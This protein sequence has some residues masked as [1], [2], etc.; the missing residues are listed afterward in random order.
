MNR[1]HYITL[2]YKE[3]TSELS[4]LEVQ[5]LEDFLQE[6]SAN[7]DLRDEIQLSWMLSQQVEK[8]SELDIDVEADLK[9]V[10]T[11][12]GK[13]PPSQQ[14]NTRRVVPLWRR[15]ATV[16]AIL[17]PLIIAGAYFF[18]STNTLNPTLIQ[19]ANEVKEAHLKDGTTV[20]L[21]R[22]S[23][24]E[25]AGD[26]NGSLR[27]VKLTGE[28]YFDVAKNADKPFVI[29]V[30][31]L[32]VSVL[33]TAFNIKSGGEAEEDQITVSVVSGSVQVE[34]REES[35]ILKK[36]EKVVYKKQAPGLSKEILSNQNEFSW[37]TGTFVYRSEPLK[38][39][40]SQLEALFSTSIEIENQAIE[41]C[42]VSIVANAKDFQTILNK[43]AD[44][45]N[46]EVKKTGTDAYQLSGGTC[47]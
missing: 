3:V 17:I 30:E 32:K 14:E 41:N 42:G 31:E 22:N 10:K 8:G 39:V 24:L 7:R 26:F 15:M 19:A 5:Q 47:D 36:E 44:A 21:N 37:K 6:S 11:R 33:G 23:S 28:A 4:D 27:Q 25:V 29:Q 34:N 13:T 12:L 45:V 2:I 20:W 35:V 1:D 46:C 38:A 43:I 18:Q 9:N 40:V 16:A